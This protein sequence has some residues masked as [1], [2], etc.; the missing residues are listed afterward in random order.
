ME[1]TKLCKSEYNNQLQQSMYLSKEKKFSNM[2]GKHTLEVK[3]HTMMH[4]YT[5]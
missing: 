1:I 3:G 2:P 4:T 5:P